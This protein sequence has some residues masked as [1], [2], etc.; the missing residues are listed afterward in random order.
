MLSSNLQARAQARSTPTLGQ[1]RQRRSRV[2][3]KTAAIVFFNIF[4]TLAAAASA[5]AVPEKQ[6]RLETKRSVGG[7]WRHCSFIGDGQK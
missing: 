6:Y 4:T 5:A 3:Q 2:K 7:Y 1:D